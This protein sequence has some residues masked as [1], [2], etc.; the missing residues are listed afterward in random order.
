M[1]CVHGQYRNLR[2][3]GHDSYPTDTC[4][5]KCECHE[6]DHAKRPGVQARRRNVVADRARA[7]RSQEPGE[8]QAD[9]HSIDA[10]WQGETCD[11]ALLYNPVA[12][13]YKTVMRSVVIV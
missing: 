5:K 1:E 7:G 9:S 6:R 3:E 8:I 2:S 10:L 11:S 12:T 4:R 13:A